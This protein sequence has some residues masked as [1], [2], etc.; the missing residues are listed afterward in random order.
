MLNKFR[1]ILSPAASAIS[2]AAAVAALSDALI[3]ICYINAQ[4]NSLTYRVI[5]F[6]TIPFA[7]G[8]AAVAGVAVLL[9]ALA[10][11]GSRMERVCMWE[12]I[13]RPALLLYLVPCGTFPG[14][15]IAV[16][17]IALVVFNLAGQ[18]RKS[19]PELPEKYGTAI[20]VAGGVIVAVWGYYLQTRAYDTLHFI[21]GDW[22][23]YV[24]HYLHLLSGKATLVQ[25]CAGAGHWNFGVNLVM[26]TLLKLWY[27]P[28]TVFIVNAL[29]I[30]SVVPL[31]YWLSRKCNLSSWMSA[32]LL[33]LTVFNPVLSNQY[34]S[35]F[36]G[37]HPIVFFVPLLMGFF[38]AREYEN[39]Y[40]MAACFLLS[41][42]V[43]ETVCIFWAGYAVYLVCCKRW[44]SGIALFA[45]MVG[46][47]FFFSS[48]VIPAAHGA[49]NY[50]QM[51]HYSQLGSTM[52][53]VL[54]SPVIRPG[55]FWGTVFDRSS[56]C[57]A[58]AVFVPLLFGIIYKPLMLISI[59]PIF[60]GVILQSSPDVKSV[61]LQYGLECT[62]FAVIVMILNLKRLYPEVRRP[63]VCAVLASTLLC[64]WMLG[65]VPGSQGLLKRL[66]N[67][68]S[69]VEVMNFFDQAAG[70]AKRIAATGRIRGQFQFQRPTAPLTDIRPGDAVIID[71][72]DK[73]IEDGKRISALRK[74]LAADLR[75]VPVTYAI[76]KNHTIVMFRILPQPVPRPAVPWLRPVPEEIFAKAGGRSVLRKDG[77]FELRYARIKDKNVY[78]LYLKKAQS[79]DIELSIRQSNKTDTTEAVIA[80]GNG[81]FPAYS[82]KPG[83]MFEFALPGGVPEKVK[84]NVYYVK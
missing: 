13:T 57:F 64:G 47:F 11:K 68:P 28:D 58:L 32:V 50:S 77:D 82:V 23:Q 31:G 71:L 46:L 26:T 62:V 8:I 59:L 12:K 29:C 33:V 83:T 67:R 25:W 20:A 52:G 49:E 30:A 66:M 56:V 1:T 3:K 24:E 2:L 37:F 6:N 51:F 21:W 79:E 41:L 4:I 15:L 35:L 9:A 19:L 53:E 22:N 80:F 10:G 54:L 43:Q 73:G 61:M 27:A 5:R 69:G 48:A 55:A 84:V 39:R 18:W 70:N 81:L 40:L 45:A 38:I 17:V 16:A 7:S 78:R 76:W 42:L 36:Y 34:L 75:A 65:M 60:A 74:K 63:A 44:K 72:H 14:I